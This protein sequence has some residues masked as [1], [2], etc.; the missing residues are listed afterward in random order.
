M[1][2][3][4]GRGILKGLRVTFTNFWRKPITTQYPEQ[5]LIPS[6]RVR[7]VSLVW[8][9]ERCT[10]CATCAKSCLQGNIFIVTSRGKDNNYV[11]E[12]FTLDTARC[13]FCGLCVEACPYDAL[14]FGREL[15]TAVWDR[16]KLILTKDQLAKTAETVCSAYYHPELEDKLQEQT[17]LLDR[18]HKGIHIRQGY[19]GD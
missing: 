3:R 13:I 17:L 15:D 4:Y 14:F 5:R 19:S 8:D 16:Q 12:H 2:G 11:V 18:P 9:K 6:K 7:G 10:G 1:S